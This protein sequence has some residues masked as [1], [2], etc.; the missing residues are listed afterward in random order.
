[1][2]LRDCHERSA[3]LNVAEVINHLKSIKCGCFSILPAGWDSNYTIPVKMKDGEPCQ[4]YILCEE[5]PEYRKRHPLLRIF[6]PRK[7]LDK[8]YIKVAGF[9]LMLNKANYFVFD[10]TVFIKNKDEKVYNFFEWKC[11]KIPIELDVRV[12]KLSTLYI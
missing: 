10:V 11:T 2:R 4:R 9:A 12:R 5:N 3:T 7:K 6:L 8:K 1:M